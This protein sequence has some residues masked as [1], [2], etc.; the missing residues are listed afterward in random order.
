MPR[1]TIK[2]I[3]DRVRVSSLDKY[4]CKRG[5]GEHFFILKKKERHQECR[6]EYMGMNAY[7]YS[8]GFRICPEGL[9]Y[10]RDIIF[11]EWRCKNC[12]R[13]DTKIRYENLNK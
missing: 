11:E 4:P 5:K 9:S 7:S 13:K 1:S 8:N 3:E 10:Y 6:G 2:K 12:N